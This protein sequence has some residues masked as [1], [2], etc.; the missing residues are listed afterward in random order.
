MSV[1]GG[2]GALQFFWSLKKGTST[3]HFRYNEASCNTLG[4]LGTM[5]LEKKKKK[6][7]TNKHAPVI[8]LLAKIRNPTFL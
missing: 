5:T 2:L 1:V 4:P 3:F 7:Q 8:Y 6:K